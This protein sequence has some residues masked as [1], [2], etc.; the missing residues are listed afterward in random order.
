VS[1]SVI[2]DAFT[3]L[4]PHY[5]ETVDREV[6]EFCGLGY[7]EFVG[8]LAALVPTENVD[9]ILDVAC[10]T[11]VSSY[12]ITASAGENTKVIGLDI[13]P[14][15]LEHGIRSVEEAGL[16][17]RIQLVCAS[18]MEMPLVAGKFDAVVCGLGMHH[19]DATYLLRE[20]DRVLKGGGYLVLAD[21]AA[22]SHWR[23]LPGRVLMRTIVTVYR[24][25][26]RSSRARAEA[27]AFLHIHSADEWREI[28]SGFG[29]EEI[30][31]TEWPPRRFWY[32][33][34]LIMRAVSKGA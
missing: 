22:P 3:E 17:S 29:F 19:M 27:A 11:A 26:K 2:I 33:S 4:A 6:R 1:D 25:I 12:E 34:A 18:A 24:L 15:M 20:I 32:P 9:I 8:Y 23:S 28:L 7:R 10:G 30:E 13:T 16:D 31:M 5:E 14:A 21:M